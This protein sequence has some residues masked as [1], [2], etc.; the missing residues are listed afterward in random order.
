MNLSDKEI[1]HYNLMDTITKKIYKNNLPL[2]LKGGTA[3]LF[4]YKLDRMSMDLDFDANKHVKLE[5]II[6]ESF[7]SFYGNNK[8]ILSNI[9]IKKDTDDVKRYVIDYK[10]SYNEE[11]FK[12]KIEMSFRRKFDITETNVINDKRIFKLPFLFD[13]KKAAFENRTTSRDLHDI[14]FMGKNYINALNAE[15]TNY[16]KSIYK[17]IDHIVNRYSEAYKEDPILKDRLEEDI[18]TLEHIV[19]N[20]LK[21]ITE[22]KVS[23]EKEAKTNTPEPDAFSKD[24]Q[25]RLGNGRGGRGR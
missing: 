7:S 8:L 23:L 9:N 20:K 16:I 6:K 14:I 19:I 25:N 3:L 24:L 11:I 18:I 10:N 1:I 12:L 22:N 13:F 15:Q 17:N 21:T 5:S 2:A 4:G